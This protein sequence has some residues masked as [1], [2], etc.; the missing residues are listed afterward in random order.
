MLDEKLIEYAA[1]NTYPFHMPGHKRNIKESLSPYDIDITEITDFDDL[2][3][4]EGI[5]RAAQ[6]RAAQMYGAD[7]CFYLVNGSTCGLLA[8]ISAL[9]NKRDKV[10]IARNCHKA[11]YHAIYLRELQPVY[12]YPEITDYNIQGQVTVDEV[13]A[14]IESNPEIKAVVITSPT[15]D[16]IVSDVASIA[17]L[18]HSYGIKLIVDEAH[19]AHF[20]LDESMPENA[21]ALGADCVIVSVHKTLPAFT[22]TALLLVN[23]QRVD[24]TRIENFLDI[25]ETSS[26]SYVLMAGIERCVRIMTENGKSLFAGLNSNLDDFYAK[27]SNLHHLKVLTQADFGHDAYEFDRTKILISTSKCRLNGHDIKKI[28]T[29]KY[30][31]EL[32]MSS[33]NYAL[34][35]ATVMDTKEGFDRLADALIEIDSGCEGSSGADID[36]H[37]VYTP[38]ERVCEIHETDLR[39]RELVPLSRAEGCVCSDYIYFYP[40][41]IPILVPGERIDGKAAADISHAAEIGIDVYGLTENQMIFILKG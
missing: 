22:Q 37:N 5:L 18:V 29:T 2:H 27:V 25:Y 24:V 8:S 40:P 19:G 38:K 7:E 32:E 14:A 11:V 6:K 39:E 9:T 36:I 10:L 15:Y 41:G 33:E 16:G 28:L 4:S 23:R 31:I 34:A 17:K 26:P 3:H 30:K 12:I 21:I 20:G 13:Q 1:T 35:L